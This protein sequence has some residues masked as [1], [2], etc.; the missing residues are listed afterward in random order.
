LTPL[1][2]DD[3]GKFGQHRAMWI[4]SPTFRVAYVADPSSTLCVCTA[5]PA[6]AETPVREND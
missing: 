3:R 4:S 6:S 5:L 1:A 2:V